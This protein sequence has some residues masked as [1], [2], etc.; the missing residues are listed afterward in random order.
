MKLRKK[1]NVAMVTRVRYQRRI[2]TR[3]AHDF[4]SNFE[5]PYI[6]FGK[7]PRLLLRK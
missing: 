7:N 2:I 1:S 3:G 4:F 6:F 5:S